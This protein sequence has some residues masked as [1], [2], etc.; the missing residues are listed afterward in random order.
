METRIDGLR[1]AYQDP[2]V[3]RRYDEDRSTNVGQRVRAFLERALLRRAF[4]EVPRPGKILDGACGTGR[5]APLLAK[6]GDRLVGVDVSAAMVSEA[7]EKR[8]T[9]AQW[10]VGDATRLPFPDASFDLVVSSR[11][12]RHLHAA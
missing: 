10:V 7:R 5:L 4:A 3:A 11:F 9:G 2:S 6:L 1:R 12:V 8:L